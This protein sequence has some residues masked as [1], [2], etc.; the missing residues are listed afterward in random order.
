MDDV[1]VVVIGGGISGLT[2]ARAL[3]LAGLRVRLFER[4]ARCGGKIRTEHAGGFVID[5]GPDTLL[6]HKPAAIALCRALGLDAALMPPLAPRTTY[7]VRQGRLRA[8]PETS[9]FGFPTD[10]K[11]LLTTRAFSWRGKARM[12]AEPL[13]PRGAQADESIASF[14]GRRFGAEAVTY[15]AEPLLA[16]I[17][18][19]NA[20]RLS[21]HALFPSFVEAERTHGSVVRSWA[22]RQGRATGSGSMSLAEGLGHLVQRLHA[23]LPAGVIRTGAPVR[24]VE[25]GP[26]AVSSFTTILADG[27]TIGSRAVVL[28]VPPPVVGAVLDGMDA[29]LAGLAAAI[30]CESSL[31]VA[32][33]YRREEV[34][35]PLQGWGL[36]VPPGE[37][38]NVSAVSCVS[39]KWLHRAPAGHVLFRVSL[40]GTGRPRLMDETDEQL[41]ARAH[42]DL[43]Q[44]L[45]IA[46]MPVLARAFRWRDAMPQFDVGHLQRLAAIE[47]RLSQRPGLFLSAAGFRGVGL[48]DCIADAQR[49]AEHAAGHLRAMS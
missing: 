36:V 6:G 13:I 2:A 41:I 45:G 15:L 34:R 24:A 11:T 46:G 39:S 22:R 8:L 9:A 31:S 25:R 29:E 12:A 19:G 10:W 3:C 32:L 5:S 44:L 43:S 30:R 49:V 37:G 27:V 20:A 1:D 47:S 40:G 35:R 21:M 23:A 42:G 14:V 4:E 38:L 33:G 48:P 28:A 18:K 17:H 7:V 26:A 16:G